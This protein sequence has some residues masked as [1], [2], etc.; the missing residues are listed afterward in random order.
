MKSD[1]QLWIETLV[2]RYEKPL[3]QYAYRITG[4][5]DMARDAVQE[6]F[7]RLCR[8]ERDSMEGREAPWLFK[9]CRTR[10][11]D[12]LRKEAPMRNF[13]EGAA[14]QLATPDQSPDQVAQQ[15]DSAVELRAAISKLPPQQQEVIRLK[16]FHHLS[17]KEIAGVTNLKSGYVGYLLHTGLQELRGVIQSTQRA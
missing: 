3:C 9:V 14:A 6:T 12:L 2:G 7:L 10:A 1:Q 15:T 8:Q 17:Y 11:L 16:F 4:N 5:P 13:E